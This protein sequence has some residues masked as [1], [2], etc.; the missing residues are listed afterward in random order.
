MEM[1]LVESAPAVQDSSSGVCELD[2]LIGERRAFSRISDSC[3]AAD[4]E[5]LRRMREEKL[6]LSKGL[7]WDEFCPKYLGISK[8]E[9]NRIIRRF[10]EF[11]QSYFDV[12][13]I[14]RISPEGYRAIAP[15]V[16]DN[17]IEWNGERIALIRENAKQ[18]AAAIHSLRAEAEARTN[19]EDEA[20]AVS[21]DPT[22]DRLCQIDRRANQLLAELRE[23]CQASINGSRDRQMVKSIAHNIRDRMFQ[24]EAQAA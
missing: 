20:P 5:C 22:Y 8:T 6:Y 19:P 1:T 12:S 3:S 2:Q 15:A 23:I 21:K 7:N 4:A 11:G 18:V 14:V 17:A 9:A 16:K 13:R 24:L 10:D